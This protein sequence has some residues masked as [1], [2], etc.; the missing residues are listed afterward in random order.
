MRVIPPRPTV[1]IW[2]IA[3]AG[4]TSEPG[5]RIDF[6]RVQAAGERK[7]SA[8]YD[9]A[10]AASEDGRLFIFG[11]RSGHGFL[12]DLWVFDPQSLSFRELPG[13]SGP[14]ARSGSTLFWDAPRKRLVLFGGYRADAFGERYFESDLWFYSEGTGWSQE[15]IAHGPV[16]RAWAAAIA[17]GPGSQA[18]DRFLIYGGY[19]AAP[20]YHFRDLWALHLEQLTWKRAATDGGPLGS[21]R[22]AVAWDGR[23]LLVLNRDGVPR[24][25][26]CG[27]WSLDL[28][29]DRW[30]TLDPEAAPDPDFDLALAS[31]SGRFVVI[32]GPD[33][34]LPAWQAWIAQ[35][36]G[37]W[38]RARVDAGPEHTTLM[39][40][41]PSGRADWLCFGG[42]SG[43][44]LSD[45]LIRIEIAGGAP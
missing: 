31:G 44:E 3:C 24:P 27:R 38:K 42:C 17:D 29:G 1:W 30:Q 14:S 10:A 6:A 11:G 2:L 12:S 7:P 20:N 13:E 36:S 4:C 35:A 5:L 8:R 16:G 39:A 37:A 25:E 28:A 22:P 26:R 19:G 34:E 21:G 41:A 9:A 45:A 32:D 23:S 40:C 18:R 43:P 15:F 33:A